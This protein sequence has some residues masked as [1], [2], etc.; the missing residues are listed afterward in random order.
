MAGG[1]AEVDR[2]FGVHWSTN[3]RLKKDFNRQVRLPTVPEVA[4]HMYPLPQYQDYIDAFAGSFCVP[5]VTAAETVGRNRPPNGFYAT[6]TWRHRKG[7]SYPAITR[8]E[9]AK[10]MMGASGTFLLGY[11]TPSPL[12]V[13]YCVICYSFKSPTKDESKHVNDRRL[14]TLY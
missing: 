7:Y 1:G 3:Q 13:P 14:L 2:H 10:N 8:A 4:T 5:S 12:T 9:K 6:L 11:F